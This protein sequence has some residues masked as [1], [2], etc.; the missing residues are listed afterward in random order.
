MDGIVSII[1]KLSQ[2]LG[3]MEELAR[4]EL[5]IKELST[6]QMHYLEVINEMSNPN[7]TELATEMRLTKPTVTVAIDKLIQKGYVAKIQSDE[8]R[9]SSHLHLTKK[10][11]QINQM[12]EHAHRQFVELMRETLDPKELEELTILLEKLTKSL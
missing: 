4:E 6:A 10:G 2:N 3:E 12:H 8:D 5:N 11:M 1:S 9:R 7:I